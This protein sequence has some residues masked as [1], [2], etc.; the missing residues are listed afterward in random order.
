MTHDEKIRFD[1]LGRSV[2]LRVSQMQHIIS[3]IG[4]EHAD[5]EHRHLLEMFI[6]N[7]DSEERE[8]ARKQ[9]ELNQK[10]IAEDIE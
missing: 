5:N 6:G 8:E 1:Y 9:E 2:Y 3:G 4:A 10:K 7:N